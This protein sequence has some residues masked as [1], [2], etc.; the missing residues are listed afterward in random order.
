[1]QQILAMFPGA[2]KLKSQSYLYGSSSL[3]SGSTQ[4][5]YDITYSHSLN[6][7][8][9]FIWWSSPGNA[10]ELNYAGVCPNLSSWQLL[11]GS[12]AYPQQLVK[13]DR[14]SECFMQNQKAFGSLYSTSHCGSATRINF[15]KASTIGGEYAAYSTKPSDFAGYSS[16]NAANK[17]YQ[18]LDLEII[19]S[20]KETLYTGISTKGSTNTLRLNIGRT[21]AAQTHAV[22]F[23]SCFD[24]ILEFDYAN[25]VINVI[26]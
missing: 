18:A 20:L 22:N 3:A 23:Y 6:S 9:Q 8:K 21:L 5:T 7:L 15:S 19:N 12:T 10:F 2:I 16:S 11:I 25:Q 1:M 24:V 14:P 4:G 17:W 26:Q 13:A